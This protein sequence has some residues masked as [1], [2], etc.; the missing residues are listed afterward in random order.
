MPS[1]FPKSPTFLKGAL[2]A[3]ESQFLGPVPNVIV[4]QYN[5]EQLSRSISQRTATPTGEGEGTGAAR[6]DAQRVPGP[7]QETITLTV[8]LSATDQL[9]EP[10]THP[11]TV[12]HGLHPALAAL[13]LLLYPSSEQF[14]L[15]QA[16]AQAGTA[17]QTPPDLPIV[18][19]VWGPSRVVPVRL[20]SFSVTEKAFDQKLNPIQAEVELGMKVLTYQDLDPDSLGYGAYLVHQVQKEALARLNLFNSA[21]QILG[22]LP[23]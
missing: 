6:R 2:I 12:N 4:F 11:H 14:L 19:F 20:T 18:L 10:G 17:Q 1:D 13:E 5:P 22:M 16:L 23:F 21:E 8:H 15:S 7:P 3:Y 9:A